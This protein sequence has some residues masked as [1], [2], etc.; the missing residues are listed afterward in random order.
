MVEPRR[1]LMLAAGAAAAVA[2]GLGASWWTHRPPAHTDL[3]ALWDM[4]FDQP[5]GGKLSM[6]SLRGQPLVI[7]FWATWCPPCIK[8]LPQL[9]RFQREFGP[10]GW[11]VLALAI[12]REQA[13]RE[14]LTKIPLK[15]TVALGG[16]EGVELGRVLGNDQ[17]GLPF[18]V[19][20]DAAGRVAQ[21]KSGQTHFDELAGWARAL[22]G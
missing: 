6:Q 16:L 12:D 13:V 3:P 2:G 14:F 4:S 17:G 11:R 7:N 22:N 19:V 5:D 15:L 8:E 21:R 18:S 1:R 9:E 20:L 10:K